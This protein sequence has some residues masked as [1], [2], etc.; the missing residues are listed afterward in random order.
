VYGLTQTKFVPLGGIS[1]YTL[2]D[3]NTVT[4]GDVFSTDPELEGH[5]YTVLTD[6]KHLFGF[7][8]AAPVVSKQLAAAAGPGFAKTVNAVSATLTVAAMRAMNKAVAID[9]QS[10]AS[11]AL[12]F[13]KANHIVP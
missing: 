13:L 6:T 11:V 9:K 7:Q 4:A 2:I 1:V 3:N 5:K 10:P 8:N 12:A